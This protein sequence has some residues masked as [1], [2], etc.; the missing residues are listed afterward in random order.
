MR[1]G[2]G[3]SFSA[4]KVSAIF[5]CCSATAGVIGWMP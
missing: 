3:I 5:C 1:I 4:K 2:F